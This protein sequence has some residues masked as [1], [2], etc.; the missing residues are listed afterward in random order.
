MARSANLF[1]AGLLIAAVL[2]VESAAPAEPSRSHIGAT[3]RAT[4]R[5]AVSVAPRAGMRWSRATSNSAPA[6][7][8]GEW[9]AWSTTPLGTLFVELRTTGGEWVRRPVRVEAGRSQADCK[10][11]DALQAQI[12]TLRDLSS[13]PALL[14]IA[15]E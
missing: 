5:I 4:V 3:S 10:S 8:V 11:N 15:P 1:H 14:L 7:P 6:H 13:G 2:S 9:C 12:A